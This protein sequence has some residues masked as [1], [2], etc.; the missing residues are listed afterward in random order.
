MNEFMDLR[1]IAVKEEARQ[2]VGTSEVA[3]ERREV[4]GGFMCRG[5]PGTW[6]N[7]AV[8]LGLAG[9]V[10]GPE[11]DAMVDWFEGV[12][13]EPRVEVAPF[14]DGSLMQELA[15]RGFVLRV[16]ENVFF[17]PLK[18]G[19]TVMPVHP[20][21][22]GIELRRV[23]GG[24]VGQVRAFALAVATGFA[25]EGVAARPA[26]IDVMARCASH[27]RT[28]ALGAYVDGAC[29][30]GGS[31]EVYGEAA[32]L[33]GLAVTAPYRKKGIQQALIAQRLRLASETGAKFAAIS[34][35]PG[36]ATERNV[37]RMG[38]EV[39]YT[40]VTMVRPRKGLV[41]VETGQ[42]PT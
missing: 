2:A 29:V 11:V 6:V 31:I 9:P 20:L 26:D 3:L 18:R 5:E 13:I 1:E 27:P 24:D 42:S 4:A 12:G 39:A 41:S 38:F 37:R 10:S 14:V 23:N 7:V 17:R 8:G 35:R 32:G 16:F 28:I 15:N 40:K 25:P 21:A 36:V 19:E 34:S 33:Y 22:P 30:G